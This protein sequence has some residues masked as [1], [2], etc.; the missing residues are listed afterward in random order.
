MTFA[1]G[2]A[3]ALLALGS[4]GCAHLRPPAPDVARAARELPSY[5]ASL[6]VSL[7]GGGLRGRGRVLLAFARPDAL[8]VEVPG[9]GGVR[10]LAVTRGGTLWAVFPGEAAWFEGPAEAEQMEALL[11]LALAPAEVMD[12]LLGRPAPRL[13]AFRAGWD[14]RLPRRVEATLPDGSRLRVKVDEVQSPATLPPAAF[15]EPPHPG[16]R[17]LTAG[18]ARALWSRR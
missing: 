14:A 1:L 13:R 8:R 16:Y 4:A 12:L 9:P 17:K 7:S 2:A 10:L 5:S 18:E 11:G 3:A 6:R 15:E